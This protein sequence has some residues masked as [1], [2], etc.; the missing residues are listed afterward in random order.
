MASLLVG[1][2]ILWTGPALAQ[3]LEEEEN[4]QLLGGDLT[5]DQ[6]GI[7]EELPEAPDPQPLFGRLKLNDQQKKQIEQMRF[8]MQK[9]LVGVRAKMQMARLDLHQLLAADNPDKAAIEAKMGEISQIALQVHST[10]LNH[11]F[12]VN[13]ILNPDQQKV[14]RGL[15][16]HPLRDRVR[17]W[18]RGRFKDGRC[19]C[20]RGPM[21][22]GRG[23][24][25]GDQRGMRMRHQMPGEKILKKMENEEPEKK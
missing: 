25:S 16:K 21:M 22:G 5:F 18:M 17:A 13:K 11:W 3:G 7:D 9:Q 10:R 19:P 14:W 24:R 20:M 8:D 2:L 15:L 23:D 6:A 1:V 4:S 12:E